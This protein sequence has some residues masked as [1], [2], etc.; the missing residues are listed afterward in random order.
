MTEKKLFYKNLCLMVLPIAFQQFMLAAVGASDAI[1]LGFLRQD[2]LSSIS[3]ATQIQ[4]VFNL[5]LAAITI[6]TSI[7]TA[8]Y[9]GKGDRNTCEKVLAIALRIA[10]LISLPFFF[11]SLLTPQLLMRIFTPDKLLIS[12]GIRYLRLV[13]PVYLLTAVS[14]IYLC[15]MKN[16]GYAMKSTIISSVTVLINILLNAL[17]IFGIGIFPELNITG[18]AAATVIAKSTELLWMLFESCR[19][20]RLKLRR[21]YLAHTDPLLRRDF[22]KYT[23]PVLGNELVWGCGFTMY[24][25]I[26]GHLGS[27]AV[28]ANSIANIAKNMIGCFCAGLANGG[29]ILVGNELGKGSLDLARKYGS[30][31]CRSTI[32]CGILAGAVFLFITPSVVKFSGL[33]PTAQ[34]YLKWMLYLC[35]YNMLGRAVNGTT[36]AGIFC[37]GGDSRFGFLCDLITMWCIMVPLGMAAAFLF[38]LPVIWVY[39]IINLDEIIKLPAVFIHYR[40]YNWVKNITR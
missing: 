33:S 4:F 7:L 23:L 14:Q 15:I 40:K 28:A 39:F 16:S 31:L 34:T 1:M 26:M 25:V 27:D 3:L 32:L 29:G 17:L 2:Y 12:Y 30:W 38:H 19:A 22:L 9:W 11:A 37:A 24:S 13:S 6:G 18:A 35:T 8:Q 5:F 20:G 10:F 36:I 21:K